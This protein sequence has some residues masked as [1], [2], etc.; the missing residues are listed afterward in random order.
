[1]T[2][3]LSDI[4]NEV[5]RVVREV[6]TEGLLGRRAKVTNVSG[7]WKFV[8]EKTSF[9]RSTVMSTFSDPRTRRTV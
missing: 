7:A 4:A 2:E 1:M 8:C 6:G 9:D 5:T 3:S